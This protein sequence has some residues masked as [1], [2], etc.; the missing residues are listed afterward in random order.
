[1]T[2]QTDSPLLGAWTGP[3]GGVPPWD[4]VDPGAFLAAFDVAIEE[5]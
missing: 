5:S 2:S 1:M 3:F 4:Q